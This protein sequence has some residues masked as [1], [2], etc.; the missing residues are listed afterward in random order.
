MSRLQEQGKSSM[1]N[2][3]DIASCVRR[4]M[5]QYFADLD[6]ET[7]SAIYDMVAGCVEK[8]LLQV[9]LHE[10]EGNQTRA[11]EMLGINRNT[12]RKKMQ[13]HGIK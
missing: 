9:I 5:E 3:N 11:A 12:L 13:V 2:E 8:P 7:P 4:A 6:G 1:M 10:A